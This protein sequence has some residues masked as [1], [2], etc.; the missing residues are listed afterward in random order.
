M[1]KHWWSVSYIYNNGSCHDYRAIHG[2]S[3]RASTE[4]E[5]AQIIDRKKLRLKGKRVGEIISVMKMPPDAEMILEIW[6]ARYYD[7]VPE[8][9]EI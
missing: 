6:A 7:F 1:K 3:V 5:A 4:D 9:V 8:I 2:E